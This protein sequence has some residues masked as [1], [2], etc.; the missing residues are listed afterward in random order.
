MINPRKP[1]RF[2]TPL[3]EAQWQQTS[4]K[5][6]HIV[7]LLECLSETSARALGAMNC[8]DARE[9]IAVVALASACMSKWGLL[10]M[11]SVVDATGH[12]STV[13]YLPIHL[14][15]MKRPRVRIEETR[16]RAPLLDINQPFKSPCPS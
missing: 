4:I 8:D 14:C 16:D 13:H 3:H 5:E 11:R 10:K 2:T 1:C 9:H 12:G 15:K 7:S 6:T